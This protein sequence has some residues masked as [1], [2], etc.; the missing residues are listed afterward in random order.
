M[1]K[2]HP[3]LFKQINELNRQIQDLKIELTLCDK[4]IKSLK[5]SNTHKEL[6]MRV[7]HIEYLRLLQHKPALTTYY[8]IIL[9]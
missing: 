2:D 4:S 8:A 9:R 7:G 1:R 5:A 3:N 6:E